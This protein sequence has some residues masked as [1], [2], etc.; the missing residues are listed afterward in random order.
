MASQVVRAALGEL[1]RQ[2]EL[3]RD[4]LRQLEAEIGHTGY[5]GGGWEN[6]SEA[7]PYLLDQLQE[8]LL[9]LLEIAEL[10]P[11][12][13]SPPG[14]SR[15]AAGYSLVLR[16]TADEVSLPLFPC[17]QKFTFWD[18]T[19][20]PRGTFF[21]SGPPVRSRT[22]QGR[23]PP[24]RLLH[25]GGRC[26]LPESVPSFASSAIDLRLFVGRSIPL[27]HREGQSREVQ[28]PRLAPTRAPLSSFQRSA[29]QR[30]ISELASRP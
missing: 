12:A 22:P 21:G 6:P 19:L 7:L 26:Y 10:L 23:F 18:T 15:R 25:P 27:S 14:S 30:P 24:A 29:L 5:Q 20:L 28:S 17:P 1:D 13:G 11:V 3:A 16:L 2:L 9:V 4:V 8:S